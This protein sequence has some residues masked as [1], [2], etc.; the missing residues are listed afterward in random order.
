M[1]DQ[2]SLS[3]LLAVKFMVNQPDEVLEG[4]PT[5]EHIS[6]RYF[7]IFFFQ[8]ILSIALH[9]D[10]ARPGTSQPLLL[11]P[12]FP[13]FD[14]SSSSYCKYYSSDEPFEL[15]I[16]TTPSSGSSSSSSYPLRPWLRDRPAGTPLADLLSM[17]GRP[18]AG[19]YT[20]LDTDVRDPPMYLELCC[21]TPPARITD[22][23]ADSEFLEVYFHGEGRDGVGTFVVLG[24]CNVHTGVMSAIKGY[25]TM[26]N[27][28]DWRGMV[29]PFGM[30]G[31]WGPGRSGGWW[32]IWP[33]GWSPTTTQRNE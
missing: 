26:M 19:Y 11:A 20:Y 16:T 18:W 29:T 17:T 21:C 31:M 6:E 25:T 5:P 4:T 22:S 30:A 24:K 3:T 14:P 23:D 15:G 28:W 27:M 12:S 2:S 10:A 9:L 1:A 33:Q 32:W 7:T 13:H 8:T